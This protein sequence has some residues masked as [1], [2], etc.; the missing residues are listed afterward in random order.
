M[1]LRAL[2]EFRADIFTIK[3]KKFKQYDYFVFFLF[4][5][6]IDILKYIVTVTTFDI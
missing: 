4:V 3:K 2:D 5:L 1:T 6:L